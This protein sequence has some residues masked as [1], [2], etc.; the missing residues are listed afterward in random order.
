M[1]TIKRQV[2]NSPLPVRLI[3]S[4]AFNLRKKCIQ[5]GLPSG[6]LDS[7]VFK[8]VRNALGGRVR[9]LVSGGAPLSADC[10]EFIRVCFGAEFSQGYG[11]TETCGGATATP[12]GMVNPYEKAGAPFS[13]TEVKLVSA[14]KY[15]V[16]S[17]IPQGEICIKGPHV[18][19]GYYKNQQKTDEAYVVEDDGERWFHTG[20]VGQWNADGTL[21]II[22]RVKDIFKLDGGE[23]IAPERLETIYSQSKYLSNIFVYGDSKKS[24]IVAVAI[25][26]AASAKKWA[27]KNGV[28][29]SNDTQDPN[30]PKEICENEEFIKVVTEDLKSI[31]EGAKLNRYEQVPAVHID[32]MYW[33]PDS[34]LVTDAMKN[35]RDPLYSHYEEEIKALYSKL[36][37]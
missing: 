10:H 17:K 4:F 36:G 8:K 30:T 32:G 26:D 1:N 34:G 15:S 20:D 16:D 29:Y 12:A 37:Q 6:F 18:T 2:A 11:L 14:G 24:S 27:D 33:T 35:K 28:K 31:A 25:P 3:F 19:L 7:T 9:F 13:C 23:Y 21:S 22:G 5:L